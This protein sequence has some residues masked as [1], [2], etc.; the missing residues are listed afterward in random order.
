[1]QINIGKK[2]LLVQYES[3]PVYRGTQE[4]NQWSR[5]V[6]PNRAAAESYYMSRQLS[7]FYGPKGAAYKSTVKHKWL[8]NTGLEGRIKQ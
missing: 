8:K 7:H 3:T 6:V 4:R 2:G 1:M 5:A